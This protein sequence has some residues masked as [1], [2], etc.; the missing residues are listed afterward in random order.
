MEENK[1]KEK[2]TVKSGIVMVKVGSG[3]GTSRGATL[4]VEKATVGNEGLSF[5]PELAG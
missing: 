1:V 4:R 3:M 2:W 5:A